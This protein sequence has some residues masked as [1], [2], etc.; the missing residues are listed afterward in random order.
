MN[1]II[2]LAIVFMVFW[3]PSTAWAAQETLPWW[4]TLLLV[5]SIST[6]ISAT[7]VW[8]NKK[9]ETFTEK[10]MGFGAWFWFIIFLQVMVYGFYIGIEKYLT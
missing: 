10:A 2:V 1:K 9:L 8:R 4:G 6:I 3:M 7:L 5:S